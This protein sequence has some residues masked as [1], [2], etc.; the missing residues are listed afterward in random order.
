M[1]LLYSTTANILQLTALCENFAAHLFRSVL[2]RMGFC[3]LPH[4]RVR[5][6]AVSDTVCMRPLT[7]HRRGLPLCEGPLHAHTLSRSLQ[8][9]HAL[10]QAPSC[11]GPFPLCGWGTHTHMQ[12]GGTIN[13]DNQLS[14]FFSERFQKG[15]PWI[16]TVPLCST[17]T[18]SFRLPRR[19][20]AHTH[21]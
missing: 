20:R 19:A 2:G 11:G 1:F 16:Q 10:F 18:N 4:F 3:L 6:L 8:R 21:A 9:V 15:F 12:G 17:R 14:T 7:T 5:A 13:L